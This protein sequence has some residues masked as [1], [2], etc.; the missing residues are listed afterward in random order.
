MNRRFI[1]RLSLGALL[2]PFLWLWRDLS[3]VHRRLQP[4]S[5]APL[6]LD[7]L[8]EGIHFHE[9]AILQVEGQEIYALSARCPHLGCHINQLREEALYC[10]CHGSRFDLQGRRLSG[11]AQEDLKPLEVRA[12]GGQLL[13]EI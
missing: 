4:R 7:P 12:E 8:R 6:R 13:I 1:L 10:P 11:P 3:A 5:R 2:F 9:E